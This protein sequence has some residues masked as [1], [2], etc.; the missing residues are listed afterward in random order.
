MRVLGDYLLAVGRYDFVVVDKSDPA[1]L[2]LVDSV[3]M[4]EYGWGFDISGRYA[5]V[6]DDTA[7]RIIQLY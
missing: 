7:L 2:T 4:S 6:G 1:N 5:I 3:P